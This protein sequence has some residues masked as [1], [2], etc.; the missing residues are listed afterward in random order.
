MAHVTPSAEGF[1]DTLFKTDIYST[2]HHFE[3]YGTEGSQGVAHSSRSVHAQMK[4][5]VVVE[6]RKSLRKYLVFVHVYGPHSNWNVVSIVGSVSDR[7]DA[8]MSY[9]HFHH[10]VILR[11]RVELVGWPSE[12]PFKNPSDLTRAHLKRI[13]N[14]VTS[15]PPQLHFVALTQQD[16]NQRI[17]KRAQDE[18]EGLVEPWVRKKKTTGSVSATPGGA[19]SAPS[20]SVPP[21]ESASSTAAAASESAPS[22]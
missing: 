12:I 11:Y 21:S 16:L 7:R 1:T 17:E 14:L 4:S 15:K 8:T 22:T 18:A 5:D 6:L 19:R 3:A 2:A 9:D 13:H 10:K 20:T